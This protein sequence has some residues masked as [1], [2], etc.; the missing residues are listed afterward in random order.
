MYAIF[1]Q[2]MPY[3]KPVH[4]LCPHHCRNLSP[5]RLNSWRLGRQ[6]SMTR[7]GQGCDTSRANSEQAATSEQACPHW[8]STC[9][10]NQV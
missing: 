5:R 1:D 2:N 4:D 9:S 8:Y 6:A 3:A 10:Y 7:S